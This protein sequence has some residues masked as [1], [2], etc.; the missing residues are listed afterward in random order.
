MTRIE[1]AAL[2]QLLHPTIDPAA[3]RKVIATGLPASPGAASGEI[4]FSADDA[5]SAEGA[6]PPRHPGAG[7]DLAGGHPRHARRRR[8]PHHARRHDLARRGGGARHGQAVRL[9][10][11]LAAGRL[12]PPAR[13][14]AG[15]HRFKQGDLI[16]IDGSTGQVLAGR[17]PMIEPALS[18]EFGT[19]MGWA[20]KVRKLGVRAN[21]DTP[22]DA[23]VAREVR[24]R[25]HRALSHRTHVLRRRPHPRRAGDD[26][27][28]RR[29]R[30]P[31]RARQASADAARRLRRA[32]RDHAG[33][34]GHHPAARSAAARVPAAYRGGNRR[35]GRSTGR[36]P[37]EAR[38][39]RP[40]TCRIQPDAR[41]PRLPPRHRLSGNRRDAG[42]RDLRGGGR[43]RQAHRQAGGAGG[44]GAADRHQARVRPG[45]GADRRHGGGGR[46]RDQDRASPTRSAP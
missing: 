43:G 12:L 22:N 44:D 6:G 24:R 23:R 8:H 11:R 13:C 36:R 10:R 7:R 14:G 40:G 3:E 30:A 17:V 33:S 21:A 38:G 15:N 26:P 9:R 37:A 16:T 2:D 46:G 39:S 28:R 34:A 27:G 41:L 5:E 18:G 42:A 1:P 45:Q 29:T 20:D 35:S 19:L 25:G 31:R 32:V 4:V